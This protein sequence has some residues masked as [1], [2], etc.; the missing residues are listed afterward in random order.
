MFEL[1]LLDLRYVTARGGIEQPL[2]GHDK[3]NKR[4]FNF[5]EVQMKMDSGE[6][7]KGREERRERRRGCVQR[8]EVEKVEKKR[9]KKQDLVL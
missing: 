3:F 1:F 8:R 7:E 2:L 5:V 6:M 9:G 4:K